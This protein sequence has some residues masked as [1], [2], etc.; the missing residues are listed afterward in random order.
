MPKKLTLVVP[1][2]DNLLLT[3]RLHT[4]LCNCMTTNLN[5]TLII[6][7][8]MSISVP[9]VVFRGVSDLAGGDANLSSTA[10]SDLA[11]TNALKV[12][13]EFIAAIGK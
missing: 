1:F 6:Q 2:L 11:S 7:T 8:A 12:A 13:V 3:K 5:N 9:V 4:K 10:L